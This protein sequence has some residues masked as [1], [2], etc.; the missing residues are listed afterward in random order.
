MGVTGVREAVSTAAS[1]LVRRIRAIT[2]LPVCV[3]IGI[4]NAAQ[5]TQ[6]ASFADGVIVASALVK[7]VLDAPDAAAGAAIVAELTAELSLAT[8]RYAD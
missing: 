3:G 2:E 1:S 6:V 4:S 8:H 7:A 5:A